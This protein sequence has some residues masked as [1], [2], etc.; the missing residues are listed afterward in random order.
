MNVQ[1]FSAYDELEALFDDDFD[2]EEFVGGFEAQYGT[3][4]VGRWEEDPEML[5]YEEILDLG[6][7]LGGRYDD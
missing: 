6:K 1:T 7:T 5:E 3:Y 2:F 4:R